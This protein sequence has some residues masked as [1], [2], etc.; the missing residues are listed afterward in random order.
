MAVRGSD[1]LYYLEAGTCQP[2]D[3]YVEHGNKQTVGEGRLSEVYVW[4]SE[5]GHVLKLN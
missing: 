2:Q 1:R 4:H 5:N 3:K